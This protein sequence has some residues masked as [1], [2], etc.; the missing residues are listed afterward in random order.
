VRSLIVQK[1][2]TPMGC[3][4][5]C[6]VQTSEYA[7]ITVNLSK[8]QKIITP[9]IKLLIKDLPNHPKCDGF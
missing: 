2:S 6:H 4:V 7:S 5:V 1:K 9:E 8:L 3:L